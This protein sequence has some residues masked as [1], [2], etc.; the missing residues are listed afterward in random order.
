MGCARL[1]V[2]VLALSLCF[3]HADEVPLLNAGFET[4]A[5]D[6]WEPPV[7]AL[8]FAVTDELA[9]SGGFSLRAHGDPDERY[10]G[11]AHLVQQVELAPIPGARYEIAGWV[12]GTVTPGADRSARLAIR[13]VNAEGTTIRYDEVW[14]Q[15]ESDSWRH[16]SQRFRAADGAVA[17]QV[18]VILSNLTP[19]DVIYLD[20]ITLKALDSLGEPVTAQPPA[21]SG[22]GAAPDRTVELAGEGLRARLDAETGLLASLELT[23]PEPLAL[24]PAAPDTTRVFIQLG[25]REVLFTRP[26]ERTTD[27]RGALLAPEDPSIPLRCRV[28][29]DTAAGCLTERVSF[30]ASGDIDQLTRLGVRHGFAPERWTHIVGALRPVRVIEA[31]E[32]TLLTYGEREGDLAPTQL[33]AWQSVTFPMAVLEGADRWVMVGSTSLDDFVTLAPNQPAGYFPSVQNNPTRIAAGDRFSF[34]LTWR[35]FPKDRALLRD[36]WRWYGEH[37]FSDNPL[38]AGLL[39]FEAHAVPRTLPPGCEVSASGFW[40]REGARIEPERVPPAANIWYF[41]WHDWINERYPTQGEWW[42]RV[43]GWARENAEGFRDA[44]ARYQA[45]G[46]R[47]YLYF[48][49]IANLAQRGTTLPARWFRSGAGGALDVYGGGYALDLPPEVAADAGVE[50]IPWG[51]YDFSA[52]D[53]RARYLRQ[54]RECMDFYRPAGIGWDMGWDPSDPGIL[55]VQAEAFEWMRAT[56]PEMRVIA[57]EASGTP[58]QWF[59]DCILIENGILYGKSVWDYEVAKAFG[60]QIASIERGHLFVRMAERLLSDEPS[61]AFPLGLA[62][63]RRFAQWSMAAEPLPEDEAARVNELA[64]R[65]NVR[66]GLRTMGLGAQW[67]YVTD[68]RY[69]PRPVPER[70]IDFMTQL[71]ALPPLQGSFTVRLN[72]AADADD[73]LYAGAWASAESVCVAVFNDTERPRPYVLTID[74]EA[75]ARHGGHGAPA[76]TE[77]FSVDSL[78]GVHEDAPDAAWNADGVTLTGEVAPFT[79]VVW[80][81]DSAQ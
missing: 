72:G 54:V 46:L 60:T 44:I 63:A 3:A 56:H 33:D 22:G 48:R 80:Q 61:W 70:L 45:D 68:A 35:A 10:N 30:E 81:G 64:F 23:E 21:F 29:Y 34:H 76:T 14:L 79:L 78:A 39:P 5:L 15:P 57:N 73:G 71:M 55:R 66:A 27:G 24:H 9:H 16:V 74:V 43:G 41:G 17:F 6:G 36:V 52:D 42:C 8:L 11:F 2:L 53:F 67:A 26:V 51:I 58:S 59:A 49:Q 47:C 65:M 19:D 1:A 4:G 40:A 25:D 77:A 12:R 62:D 18:Y 75:L 69:G 7:P 50:R 28:L 37:V 13:E 38:L 32:S 31:G 20:D